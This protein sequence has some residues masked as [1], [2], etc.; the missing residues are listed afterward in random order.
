[1]PFQ[2]TSSQQSLYGDVLLDNIKPRP[3]I[4]KHIL[5]QKL[6]QQQKESEEDQKWLTE[7]EI[8]LVIIIYILQLAIFQCI[9]LKRD[10]MRLQI[11]L[12]F[13]YL[14]SEKEIEHC[15]AIRYGN[16]I[17]LPALYRLRTH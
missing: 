6:R 1:M 16:F 11:F 7:T 5:E 14:F 2:S 3:V 8:N 9:L 13:A 12:I 4:E 17:G 10:F 15:Y